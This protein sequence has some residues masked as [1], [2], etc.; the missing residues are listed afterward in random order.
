MK[1]KA[2]LAEETMSAMARKETLTVALTFCGSSSEWLRMV[3]GIGYEREDSMR[4]ART[5]EH[6][7]TS[8]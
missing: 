2:S 5:W 1:S 8:E 3:T 7:T 4:M 6:D